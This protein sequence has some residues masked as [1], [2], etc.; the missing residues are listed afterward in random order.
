MESIVRP[1]TNAERGGQ[2][3]AARLALQLLR[4]VLSKTLFDR[5]CSH[6]AVRRRCSM[7][8]VGNEPSSF[9]PG[10]TTIGTGIGKTCRI[11]P[12]LFW[13]RVGSLVRRHLRR[14]DADVVLKKVVVD[15][16]DHVGALR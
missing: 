10:P 9:R 2:P 6:A 8:W 14:V 7:L 15:A 11:S 4:L 16:F 5:S 13:H 3:K 12:G 1:E